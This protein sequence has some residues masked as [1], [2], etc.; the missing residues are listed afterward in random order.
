MFRLVLLLRAVVSHSDK[1]LM[2]RD[3]VFIVLLPTLRCAPNILSLLMEYP[4]E[5]LAPP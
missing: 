4:D 3:N 2:T 5:L 1:N